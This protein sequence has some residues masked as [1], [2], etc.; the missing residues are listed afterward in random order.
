MQA[1]T[2]AVMRALQAND[3][4]MLTSL[5]LDNLFLAQGPNGDVG[6]VIS[7]ADAIKWLNAHWGANRQVASSDYVEHTVM[8]EIDTTGWAR[9]APL[10]NGSIVF[11]L[12][13]YDAQGESDG[14]GGDWR[15]DTIIY[16]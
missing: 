8:V 3:A 1:T 5:L 16:Q 10:Q 12:H 15:I 7:R 9:A 14:L 13:R 2:Q 4:S 11:H 6:D